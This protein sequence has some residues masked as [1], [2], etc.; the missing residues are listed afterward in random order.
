MAIRSILCYPDPRLFIPAKPVVEFDQNLEK[1]VEDMAETMY[2]A[3]G[4][5]LAA[6]Q[7]NVQKQVLVLDI[8][9]TKDHLQVFINPVVVSSSP[10][11]KV[12][13][14]GCLSVPGFFDEVERPDAIVVKAQDIR[15]TFFEVSADGLFSV[16]LQHEMDHL[17]GKV[18]VQYLSSL[19]QERIRV[20]LKKAAKESKSVAA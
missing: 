5:G 9:E 19:K 4:I 20:K 16:C 7:I 17:K 18:F 14:E 13:E 3:P 6:T 10:E 15:G 8:S 11:I 1:L 2:A 12:W